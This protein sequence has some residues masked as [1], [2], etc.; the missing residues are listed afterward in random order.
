[1]SVLHEAINEW[2]AGQIE[3][4]LKQRVDVN[5]ADDDGKTPLMLAVIRD[6]YPEYLRALL[7]RRADLHA[8]DNSG[9][10]ALMLALDNGSLCSLEVLLDHYALIDEIPEVHPAYEHRRLAL[11]FAIYQNNQEDVR[12]LLDALT[13]PNSRNKQGRTPLMLAAE[14]GRPEIAALLLEYGAD[15]HAREVEPNEWTALHVAAD[16]SQ[17][18]SARVLLEH[19]AEVDARDAE[20]RTP[21]IQATFAATWTGSTSTIRLL[22]EYGAD[23]HAEDKEG[24]S[25][26]SQ[27]GWL[28][29]EEAIRTLFEWGAASNLN[30]LRDAFHSAF[31]DNNQD[32]IPLF[33]EA[34][35]RIG[36]AE[37]MVLEDMDRIKALLA[38]GVDQ[39]EKNAALVTAAGTSSHEV[40]CLLLESGADAKAYSNGQTALMQAYWHPFDAGSNIDVLLQAGADVNARNEQGDTPFTSQA[41]MGTSGKGRLALMRTLLPY[42]AD[43]NVANVQGTTALMSAAVRGET[44]VARF[45]LRHGAQINFQDMN[46][47][48]ALMF[49]VEQGHTSM[50]R[51]LL[52][53]GADVQAERATDGTTALSLSRRWPGKKITEILLEAGATR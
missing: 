29:S 19:G 4:L 2:N 10:T 5:E 13:D 11:L 25:A 44:S 7:K 46:G 3:W 33:I 48:T 28:G 34:G 1:L 47:C 14:L 41:G 26:L 38:E 21:L 12:T 17:T 53:R 32:K 52:E 9:N 51:L 49:A 45:L 6:I 30:Q 20:Q 23:V 15:V 37:A 8:T 35:L 22:L 40:L 36:L 39:E 27:A 43:V 16:R 50:V 18:A 31:I 42:G 24:S